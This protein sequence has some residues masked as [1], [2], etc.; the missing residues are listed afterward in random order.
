MQPSAPTPPPAAV[1]APPG[2]PRSSPA[3][4]S[5][6]RAALRVLGLVLA[7]AAILAFVAWSA[8]AIYFSNLPSVPLRAASASA[9]LLACLAA[10]ARPRPRPRALA[11]VLAACALVFLWFLLI[12][13]SN[14]RDWQPDVAVLPWARVE[15]DLVTI[16]NLRHCLYRSESDYD[17]RLEDVSVRLSDL[18][19]VDLIASYWGSPHIC[20][21]MI[22]FGFQDGRQ[23]CISV[24]ARREKGE[25]Y[26]ALLG[27]FRRFELIYVVGDER[28]LIRLRTNVRGESVYLYRLRAPQALARKVFMAYLQRI[29]DLRTNPR[30]YHA[31]TTNCTT[32]ARSHIH[33][34]VRGRWDWRFLLNGHLDALAHQRGAIDSSLPFDALKQASLVNPKALATAPDDPAFSQRIRQP[35]PQTGGLSPPAPSTPD[36]FPLSTSDTR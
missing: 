22:S 14:N 18:R 30:W 27:F 26:S 19:S 6:L 31:G 15:G 2:P 36:T 10:L 33:P 9:F 20:H 24:E 29:N 32:T 16:H 12:P 17:V 5:A 23:L 35:L 13:P 21:T 7:A 4:R 1:Q 28:D 8:A 25:A 3:P 34:F 11:V